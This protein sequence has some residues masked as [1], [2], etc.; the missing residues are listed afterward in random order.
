VVDIVSPTVCPWSLPCTCGPPKPTVLSIHGNFIALGISRYQVWVTTFSSIVQ[1]C[2]LLTQRN[3]G[4][5][6]FSG[7]FDVLGLL[8]CT[9]PPVPRGEIVS[10]GSAYPPRPCPVVPVHFGVGQ[11][12]RLLRATP[13]CIDPRVNAN[14][15]THCVLFIG[16]MLL[17]RFNLATLLCSGGTVHLSGRPVRTFPFSPPL[18]ISRLH[19][20]FFN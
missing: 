15:V 6:P 17:S 8:T 20:L 10:Y 1:P 2:D 19:P 3:A 5:F 13:P 18:S 4:V 9:P 11:S 14:L 12:V 7:M 16:H